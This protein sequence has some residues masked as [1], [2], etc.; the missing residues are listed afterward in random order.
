MSPKHIGSNETKCVLS[1]AITF[2]LNWTSSFS[3]SLMELIKSQKYVVV[4]HKTEY[5]VYLFFL[6]NSNLMPYKSV[7]LYLMLIG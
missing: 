2:V 6:F 4:L 5:F 3:F 1:S 7:S